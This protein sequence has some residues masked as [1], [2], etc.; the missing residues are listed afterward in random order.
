MHL[1]EIVLQDE[2]YLETVKK[3]ENTRFITDGKWDWEHG[4]GHYKRVLEYV[5]QIL[6][7]LKV[8][9]RTLELGMLSAIL[10]DIGLS[11]GDKVDHAKAGSKIFTRFTKNIDLSNREE[12]IVKQAI[13]D[14]SKGNNIES[15]V[16]LSLVLADKLDVTYHRVI[17]SSIQDEI[18]REFGKIKEVGIQITDKDLIVTYKTE[19]DFDINILKNW[20]KAITIPKKVTEYL[21]KNYIFIHNGKELDIVS[22]LE[23]FEVEKV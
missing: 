11:K 19:L 17:H 23:S 8:D 3:I 10:H 21:G 20:S 12:E 9:E 7:Q 14:H 4:L 5:K 2:E 15:M 16:G 13:L 1:Y 22:L 6:E 18:N